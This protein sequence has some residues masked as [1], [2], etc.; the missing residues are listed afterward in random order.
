MNLRNSPDIDLADKTISGHKEALEHL[1]RVCNPKSP[2]EINP[3]MIRVF[4]LKLLDEGLAARTINKHIAA[5]RS[6]LSYAVRAEVVPT[7]KLFGPHRLFLRV[8]WKT[9]RILEVGEV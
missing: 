1:V 5:I 8:E 6:A 9:P 7:N 2:I 3:K 4:R